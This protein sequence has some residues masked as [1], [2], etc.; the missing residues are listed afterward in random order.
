MWEGAKT[1]GKHRSHEAR[2]LRFRRHTNDG[3]SEIAQRATLL[4]YTLITAGESSR[5][6]QGKSPSATERFRHS[7]TLA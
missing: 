6:T 7:F 1:T 4:N 3:M 5:L 2:A